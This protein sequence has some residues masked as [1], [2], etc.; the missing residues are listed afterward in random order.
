MRKKDKGKKEDDAALW[1]RVTSEIKPIHSVRYTDR[2]ATIIAPAP[3]LGSRPPRKAPVLTSPALTPAP[4]RRPIDLREG[5]H[6]GLDG[7][8]RRKLA[9]GD[10]PV[11][12]R[13]DLHGCSALQAERRL[14]SFI[15]D[16]ARSA[17]RCVLVIT[18][19]GNKGEGVLR[20]HVPFW[21][22]QSPLADHVLAIAT[23]KPKDGGSGAIYVM[24]R[25]SRAAR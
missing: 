21:L 15:L 22:K 12:A 25:R 18:G 5:S 24:L 3:P 7:T 20:R 10:L 19:K 14:K 23:A 4:A 11:D 8:T 13:I 9:K 17:Y 6:A 1:T 2:S 16:S